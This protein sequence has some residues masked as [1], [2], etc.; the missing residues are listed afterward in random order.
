[1]KEKLVVILGPTA[2][3]KTDLSIKL[4]QSLQSEIISGDSML[5]YRG[6]DIG[7]AKPG[8]A[9]QAGI[10]HH[11]MD[12]LEPE[13]EFSVTRFKAMAAEHI[14]ESNAAGK[15]PILA[16]GTG[17]YIKSLL[18][19]YCF[20]ATKGDEQY[21]AQLEALA[22]EKGREHVHTMLAAVDPE[23]AERLHV[24][25][26]RRV[27]RALEVYHMGGEKISQEKNAPTGELIYDAYVIGLNRE[28]T[29]LYARINER[30]D[31]MFDD[32]LVEEVRSLLARG[33]DRSCQA[34]QGIGYKEVAAALNGEMTLAQARERIKQATRHF[35]KR[36]L[37]WYRK[38]PYIHWYDVEGCG[39]QDLLTSVPKDKAGKFGTK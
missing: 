28:R 34:M 10:V 14:K 5:L 39:A 7:T 9:E 15:I 25:D 27:I 20:N 26:F 2:V 1:M 11:M 12:I 22:A 36:Q 6:F 3:G 16:G 29:H 4:A 37:T 32:G 13:E 38:M 33:L 23:A 17:L 30:V 8:R 35:A 24:N 18:E 31:K 21:R 19:D